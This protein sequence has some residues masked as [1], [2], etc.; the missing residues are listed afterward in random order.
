ME[1][2]RPGAAVVAMPDVFDLHHL[3]PVIRQHHAAKRARH[4]DADFHDLQMAERGCHRSE[5]SSR[6]RG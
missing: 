2:R 4:G 5:R 6:L 1:I 3:G